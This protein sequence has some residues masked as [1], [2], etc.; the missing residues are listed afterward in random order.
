MIEAGVL[1]AAEPDVVLVPHVASIL[2]VGT[3]ATR[4]GVLLAGVDTF[5][6]RVSGEGGHAALDNGIGNPLEAAARI[7]GEFPALVSDLAHGDACCAATL[8]VLSGGTAFNVVPT[9]ASIEGSLRTF[10]TTERSTAKKRLRA[11]VDKEVGNGVQAELIY[12]A[13]AEPV[14]N[15]RVATSMLSD[16]ARSVLGADAV[17]DPGPLTAS[18]DAAEFL[19]RLP[20]CY[21][22]V[23]A[24]VA[25]RQPTQHHSPQFHIDEE[26]LKNGAMTL[27]RAVLSH[28]GTDVRGSTR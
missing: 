13:S 17:V 10:T 8:G 6:I 20:G 5:E 2:P 26:A 9:A 11:L 4:P 23:G 15:D 12:G 3:V 21:F 1:S 18:D 28:G 25:G 27:A 16:A 14:V 22:L 7:A 24:A 19:A